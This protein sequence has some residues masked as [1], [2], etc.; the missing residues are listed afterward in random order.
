MSWCILLKVTIL[1]EFGLRCNSELL[2][3]R[4]QL[5]SHV[6]VNEMWDWHNRTDNLKET[7]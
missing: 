2:S 4:V 7:L 3:T 6:D 1:G 5:L